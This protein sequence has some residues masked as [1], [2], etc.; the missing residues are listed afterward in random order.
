MEL[1]PPCLY[2]RWF[3]ASSLCIQ[4]S[5]VDSFPFFYFSLSVL[6]SCQQFA[7]REGGWDSFFP[8]ERAGKVI[9]TRRTIVQYC[10]K[11]EEEEKKVSDYT[12]YCAN[13][14]SNLLKLYYICCGQRGIIIFAFQCT[15]YTISVGDKWAC[16]FVDKSV[17]S[18]FYIKLF[19]PSV[20]P[21][22]VQ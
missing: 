13:T 7:L 22:N 14:T 1:P 15:Y 2:N 9:S 12:Y 6:W 11:E 3:M 21:S 19:P 17:L 8:L 4:C 5:S 16:W 20:F 18:C 10:T